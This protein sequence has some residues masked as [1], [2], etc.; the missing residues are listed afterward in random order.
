MK[1][2]R[3]L[4]AV[5]VAATGTSVVVAAAPVGVAHAAVPVFINEIHYDNAGTDT[6]EMIE[7]AGPAGTDLGGWQ[8]VLYNGSN[9]TVYDSDPLTGTIP[10]E[11]SGFGAVALTYPDNG[12]QN[13]APD[14]IALVDNLGSVVQFLSY[15]GTVSAVGGPADAMTSVDIGVSQAGNEAIGLTLQ[16][17]G[18]GTVYEDFSWQ[19]PA[20][21]SPGTLN[22]GQ[23][24]GTGAAELVAGDPGDQ[25]A[26]V[27]FEIAPIVLSATGGTPPYTFDVDVD[28]LPPGL[29]FDG[30]Q[31][32]GTP[33][34]AGSTLVTVTVTDSATPAVTDTEDFTITVTS[35]P[36]TP[37]SAVQGPGAAT[38]IPN[39]IVQVQGVVVGDYEGPGTPTL[40]G[41]Y[42]QSVTG[43]GDDATSEGLFVFN[44]T[45]PDTDDVDLG[46]L[47][48]VVGRVGE[49]Q[50]QTQLTAFDIRVDG[51]G[52][53]VEP[54]PIT[55]PWPDADAPEAYEGML[56]TVPQTMYV[57]EYFQ[58]ARFGEVI[59]SS[60][61]HL[62]QPTSVVAPGEAAIDM[63][64][65]NN[66]TKL[67][68]DDGINNQNADPLAMFVNGE[69]ISAG[70]GDVP[71][72]PLRGG[73]TI[74]GATGVLTYTW[75]GN[76]S[77]G[78]K[79]RLRPPTTDAVPAFDFT[80]ANPRPVDPPDVGGS[81]QVVGFNV[82][83][84]FVTLGS[85]PNCGTPQTL[86]EDRN[87]RGANDAVEYQRQHAKLV[88]ALVDIDAHVYGFAELENT[89]G[90]DPL[91]PI[92]ASL[93]VAAGADVWASAYDGTIGTDVIKVGITYR[94]DVVGLL[95]TAILDSEVSS[96]FNDTLHR[97]SLAASF[98]ELA[99]GEQLTVVVNHWKSKGSCPAAG[100]PLFTGNNDAGDG[101]SCWNAARTAAAEVMLEWLATHPTGVTDDDV[102]VF[103]DLNSY[104]MESPIQTMLGAGYV[105]LV[106]AYDPGAHSYVF[107]GQ[108]GTLDY[109]IASPSLAAQVT[110]AA[111]YHIN[112]DELPLMDYNDDFQ[113][114]NQAT[115]WYAPDQFRTSDHDPAVVGI[116]LDSVNPT[117]SVSYPGPDPVT[118]A[119]FDVTVQFSEDVSGFDDVASD[120]IVSGVAGVT[121]TAISGSGN[122]YTVTLSVPT[123]SSGDVSISVPAGSATDAT[124]NPSEASNTLVVGVDRPI[125]VV[126]DVT[127]FLGTGKTV[128]AS[129]VLSGNVPCGAPIQFTVANRTIAGTPTS[130][131]AGG[132]CTSTVST[133]AGTL[134]LVRNTS[135]GQWALLA[136]FKS[137]PGYSTSTT[138]SLTA[139]SSSGSETLRLRRFL[140]AWLLV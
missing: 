97:P 11:G 2:L 87:C 43:D 28:E 116:A 103:G 40:R 42:V 13:G 47:V 83:N 140:G 17:T 44:N 139:G 18:T 111:D 100:N 25:I 89:T 101:A 84:Y 96:E 79:Y 72:N 131:A 68:L 58:T 133:G 38:P 86:P 80:T 64:A 15:E 20:A 78:N 134:V 10:D 29:A 22:A 61:D 65:A 48:T 77:S 74:S 32:T 115:L 16:L 82:L 69:L 91:A 120:V 93:N 106:Q 125:P 126:F 53:S 37:I 112:A 70:H 113:T 137:A 39:E 67:V 124:G 135:T 138:V 1:R 128:I 122:S 63:Q 41:F 36:A 14:A 76:S 24:F 12:I 121:A 60:V 105:D 4:V 119:T 66:L 92:V 8:I 56:V 104:A 35:P 23:E 99:T 73:D 114:A 34:E 26:N 9:G 57:T 117:A 123:G 127:G 110:G 33:T 94:T 59:V 81:L 49:N 31:I 50:G 46:D 3:A 109:A 6:G 5:A 54:A 7:V 130:R 129:G 136:Q 98:E 95:G 45:L 118:A 90:V 108:W 19:A 75:S 62:P 51:S 102:L 55:L 107:D 85:G 21:G 88:S 52:Y 132:A 30:A 71:A 27:G